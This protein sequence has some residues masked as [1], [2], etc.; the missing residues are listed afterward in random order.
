MDYILVFIL[1]TLVGSFVSNWVYRSLKEES[2]ARG[3]SKCEHCKEN[4][5][6]INLV[7]IFSYL[8]QRG[9]CSFCGEDIRREIFYSEVLMATVFLTA[10]ILLGP[11]ANYILFIIVFPLVYTMALTDLKAYIVFDKHLSLLAIISIFTLIFKYIYLNFN[12]YLG[13]VQLV[14]M[15]LGLFISRMEKPPMGEGDLIAIACLLSFYDLRGAFYFIAF[16]FWTGATYG[17]YRL[18]KRD[19][20]GKVPLMPFIC[21]GIFINLLFRRLS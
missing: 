1:G 7:P 11:S 17:L 12:P 14:L 3:R 13:L 4:L 6:P 2:V 18:Y 21:L 8:K 10:Y 9:R 5:K 15:A 16:T 19:F 20:S